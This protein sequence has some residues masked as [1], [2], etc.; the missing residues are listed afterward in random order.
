M[1]HVEAQVEFESDGRSRRCRDDED[2]IARN[3]VLALWRTMI[4]KK[5]VGHSDSPRQNS[6][7]TALLAPFT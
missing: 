5:V 1:T 4:G 3:P 7:M 2:V 6:R